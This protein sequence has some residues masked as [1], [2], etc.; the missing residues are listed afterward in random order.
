[1]YDSGRPV[2]ARLPAPKG[3]APGGPLVDTTGRRAAGLPPG[4]ASSC[5]P[6]ARS[7][8]TA[9]SVAGVGV[10]DDLHARRD[11]VATH[12][13]PAGGHAR[14]HRGAGI[15]ACRLVEAVGQL[16][17]LAQRSGGPASAASADARRHRGRGVV[18]D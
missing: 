4:P 6:P 11:F 17:E 16:C 8:N 7:P 10:A 3:K 1:M 15:E 9:V 5:H 2:H 14:E 12:H 18:A 13:A